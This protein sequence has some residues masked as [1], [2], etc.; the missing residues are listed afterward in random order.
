MDST[1]DPNQS[2]AFSAA[3]DDQPLLAR[4][5]TGDL[6]CARCKYNLR[7]LSIRARCPECGMSVRGTILAKVDPHA[8]ELQPIA[9]PRLVAAGLFLWPLCALLAAL[10]LWSLR[11]SE[12]AAH[13]ASMWVGQAAVW[14]TL[15]SG[16]GATALIRP[17]AQIPVDG[18]ARAIIGVLLYLP[19]ALGFHVVLTRMDSFVPTPFAAFGQLS[20]ERSAVRL[21]CDFLLIVIIACLRPNARLFVH[22]SMLLRSGKVDRQTMLAMVGALGVISVGDLV[23]LFGSMSSGGTEQIAQVLG[24]VLI[25]VGSMFFTVGIFGVMVDIFRILPAVLSPP[26]SLESVTDGDVPALGASSSRVP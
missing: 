11:A 20:T 19:L 24:T 26:I 5:L 10:C 12:L 15:F 17:H 25:A 1:F 6:L 2:A 9:H 23:H 21:C 14:F 22:R 7:G 16:L 18:T 3:P 8:S 13:P 4:E